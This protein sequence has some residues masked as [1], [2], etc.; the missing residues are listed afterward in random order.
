MQLE[1]RAVLAAERR[2]QFVID[3]HRRSSAVLHPLTPR[4]A[5]ATLKP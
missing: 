3:A 4:I 5:S 2:E 1:F